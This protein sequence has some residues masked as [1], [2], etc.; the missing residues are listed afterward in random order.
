MTT[1]RTQGEARLRTPRTGLR[2][3]LTAALA[4]SLVLGT[5][6]ATVTP[7]TAAT[8]TALASAASKKPAI[9]VKASAKSQTRGKNGIWVSAWN[10]LD[11]RRATTGTVYV[12]VDKWL[13][14]KKSVTNGR[15]ATHLS[16]DL[17][18]GKRT[19]KVTFIPW[20][21]S[22][23]RATK[24]FDLTV[25]N[26]GSPVVTE[27]KKHIGTPYRS[28]GTSP[29]GF[30]CS[31]FT[32]YVYKKSG[33]KKLPRTSSAQRNVGKRISKSS[34]KPGDLIW[35]PGHVAIYLGGN[36]QIDAPRPGKSVQVRQIWQS[37]PTFIRVSNKAVGA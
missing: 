35:S 5:A 25:K 21:V 14:A 19:V 8:P 6:V 4:S 17:R 28:G 7:A 3:A 33:V 24:T 26:A 20:G 16:S 2:L 36:K 10:T 11:G 12:K 37:N 15:I 27:A 32:S 18:A 9:E 30:D 13:V 31:G 29:S 1:T 34:A 22:S 23:K